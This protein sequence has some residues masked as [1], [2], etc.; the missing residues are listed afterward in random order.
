MARAIG[1]DSGSLWPGDALAQREQEMAPLL[2][3]QGEELS[4]IF[5]P[6]SSECAV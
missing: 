2:L 6:S 1:P 3:C 5:I 4:V